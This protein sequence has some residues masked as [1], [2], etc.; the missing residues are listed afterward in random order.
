VLEHAAGTLRE[1]EV[2]T[3]RLVA[4]RQEGSVSRAARLLKQSHVSLVRWL[5]RRHGGPS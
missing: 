1:I 4:L 3:L 5:G 2:A